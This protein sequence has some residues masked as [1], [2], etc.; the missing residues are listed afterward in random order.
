MSNLEVQYNI[1]DDIYYI[2]QKLSSG[3]TLA[4][5]FECM[6]VSNTSVH[7]NIAMELYSKRNSANHN[8]ASKTLTGKNPLETFIFARKMFLQLQNV[9]LQENDDMERIISCDWIDNRRRDAYYK[10]LH[11]YGYEYGTIFGE[12]VIFKKFPAGY[13]A[14]G[15]PAYTS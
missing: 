15:H 3:Q 14:A 8:M 13:W 7:W 12:K 5:Y 9:V 4:M 11:R 2:K 6:H 1:Q 10:V